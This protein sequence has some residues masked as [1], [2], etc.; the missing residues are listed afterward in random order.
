MKSYLPETRVLLGT[1]MVFNLGFYAVIPFLAGAMGGDYGLDAAAVGLVLGA[2]TFSQQG[3]FLFGGLLADRWG[4]RRAILAGCLVRI[5]GYATLAAASDFTLFLLGAVL[6]GAGGALFSPALES[7]LSH[8]DRAH[9]SAEER[10]PGKGRR[11]VFVWLAITG[12]MGALVGPLLG[13]ALL[14]WGFDAALAA[15]IAIFVAVTVL[16]WFR[17]PAGP[18]GKPETAGARDPEATPGQSRNAL[19][20]LKNRRFVAFCLL[21]STNMVAYNQLYFAF[22]LELDRRGLDASWLAMLFLLAS[23]LTLLLQLPV[24][25]VGQRLGPGRAMSAGFLLEAAALAAAAL[26]SVQAEAG[27]AVA[28]NSGVGGPVPA[29]SAEA[30]AVALMA[31]IV[32]ALILGHMLL[33]PTILSLIPRFTPPEGAASGRGAYYGLS[34]T[35]GGIAVLAGNALLG[36]LLD[37]TDRNH[38][39]PGTPW[40]PMVGLAVLAALLLP[41]LLHGI[42]RASTLGT[43]TDPAPI[44]N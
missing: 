9:A 33:R 12:E 24:A 35:C 28:G 36:W 37:L 42:H 21:A 17:L 23:V 26:T 1:Q 14:G 11:S 44:P 4:A 30:G 34:A 39:W 43:A 31:G 40:L 38:W 6:T 7:R 10:A 19:G 16:L 8:A 41:R 27:G 22:P 13:A 20:C 25:G 15:G 32:G 5:A 29:G 3:M 18:P 2:R